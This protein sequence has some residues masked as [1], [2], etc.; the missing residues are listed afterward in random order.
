MIKQS[1]P[2]FDIIN[3]QNNLLFPTQNGSFLSNL[4]ASGTE[5]KQLDGHRHA[6][7]ITKVLV[8]IFGKKTSVI[9]DTKSICELFQKEGQSDEFKRILANLLYV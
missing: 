3:S 8:G 6:E 9:Y 2:D 1:N 5:L 7:E 4:I